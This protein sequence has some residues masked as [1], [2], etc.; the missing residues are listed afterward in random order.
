MKLTGPEDLRIALDERPAGLRIG[1]LVLVTDHTTERDFRRLVTSPD[2]AVYAN[3]V[4]YV[5]PATPAN[6]RAMQPSLRAAAAAI[7]P[8]EPL[9]ALAYACTA[10]S[11]LIGD[12][13]VHA[14]LAEARPGTP[15]VTPTSAAKAALDALGARRIAL[16]AP[17]SREVTELLGGYFEGL[18]LVLG[19]SRYLGFGDDREI[20]RIAPDTIVEAAVATM[21]DDAEA[22]FISCT[23][24]RAAAL[25]PALEARLGRPV[26]TSN[27]ALVWQALRSAGYREPI[28]GLGRLG[29]L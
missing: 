14:A 11:A 25:V 6:L 15:C 2:V 28:D 12:D 16:L 8:D 10:A 19:A 7:L 5:N 3:R 4:P 17:Y 1:L 27:Q 13:V 21:G 20:A 24:L 22:L 23:A 9:D 29:R 26:V 18:G